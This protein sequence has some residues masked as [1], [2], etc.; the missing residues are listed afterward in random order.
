MIQEPAE[1]AAMVKDGQR[2]TSEG[3]SDGRLIRRGSADSPAEMV[4]KRN[5]H[6]SGMQANLFE[7]LES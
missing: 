5:F 1:G 2:S 3:R 7:R 6:F 4:G